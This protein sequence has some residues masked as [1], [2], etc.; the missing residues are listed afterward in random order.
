METGNIQGNRLRPL[1]I[2]AF[3]FLSLGV[4]L[5]FPFPGSHKWDGLMTATVLARWNET[6]IREI[7]FFAHPLVL[8]ITKLFDLLLPWHDPLFVSTFRECFF[9]AATASLSYLIGFRLWGRLPALLMGLAYLLPFS[10]WMHTTWAE[11]KDIMMFFILLFLLPFL[12]YHG[13]VRFPLLDKVPSPFIRPLL[14]ILLALAFMVHMEAALLVPFFIATTLI[15]KQKEAS[16]RTPLADLIIILSVSGV[17]V[18]IF[19]GYILIEINGIT[20]LAGARDWFLSYHYEFY[21]KTS[22]AQKLLDSYYGFRTYFI[23]EGKDPT[24]R[25]F[26]L[27]A[28]VN[29]LIMIVALRRR[30]SLALACLIYIALYCANFINFAPRDPESWAG[31]TFF[32]LILYGIFAFDGGPTLRPIGLLL[33]SVL[34]FALI[35]HDVHYYRREIAAYAPLQEAVRKIDRSRFSWIER[36]IQE[37]APDAM[38]VQIAAPYLKPDALV[39][40]GHR[41]I[42]NNLLLYTSADPLVL[43]YL[44]RSKEQ[45]LHE[46]RLSVLSMFFYRPHLDSR[47]LAFQTRMGRPLYHITTGNIYQDG[48]K[49]LQMGFDPRPLLQVGPY[50]LFTLR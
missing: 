11:E 40:V 25:E 43:R 14:G 29:L 4:L 48:R 44:D 2:T 39:S 6:P 13:K 22:P 41:Y 50:T 35:V 17:L 46:N 8:P 19:Y 33:G 18:L 9:A 47:E 36:R 23:G 27:C 20:T 12:H 30:F 21:P 37:H 24:W 32:L 49:L 45:L 3:F 5:L 7:L 10:H 1:E 26:G 42:A 15:W 34:L 28:T 16:W 38:F 31:A